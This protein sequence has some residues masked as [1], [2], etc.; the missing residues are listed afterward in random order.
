MPILIGSVCIFHS[1][2]LDILPVFR[3][4]V[5]NLVIRNVMIMFCFSGEIQLVSE[6][7]SAETG[8]GIHG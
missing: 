7:G 4:S 2:F 5:I 1:Y 8:G 6:W 3:S